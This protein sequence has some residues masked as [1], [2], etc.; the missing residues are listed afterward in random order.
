MTNLC[1]N[2][3]MVTELKCLLILCDNG[4]MISHRFLKCIS[5][6]KTVCGISSLCMCERSASSVVSDS[7]QP[8]WTAACQVPLSMGLSRQEYW[9]GLPCPPPGDLS[10]PG[11]KPTSL[12]TPALTCRFHQQCHLGSPSPQCFSKGNNLK[13]TLKD[14]KT[15]RIHS[16]HEWKDWI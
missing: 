15:T 11:I 9:S 13:I 2:H 3:W 12:L 6:L 8:P 10:D 7:L 16:I 1:V 4:K 5:K 14:M